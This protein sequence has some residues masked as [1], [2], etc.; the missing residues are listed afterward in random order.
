MYKYDFGQVRDIDKIK[1]VM[2]ADRDSCQ[3]MEYMMDKRFQV[4]SCDVRHVSS[5]GKIDNYTMVI[6]CSNIHLV[7]LSK[8]K[9]TFKQPVKLSE[10]R[11]LIFG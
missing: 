5:N 2:V 9:P 6:T 11:K 7:N 4:F 10:V 8:G 1:E 3:F